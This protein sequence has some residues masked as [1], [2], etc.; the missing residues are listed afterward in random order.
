MTY[1]RRVVR[2]LLN[3]KDSLASTVGVRPC[4]VEKLSKNGVKGLIISSTRRLTG[5]KA[6][7]FSD[8]IF[9]FRV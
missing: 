5:S 8:P 2:D 3:N 1:D 7:F 6:T 9:S 4:S